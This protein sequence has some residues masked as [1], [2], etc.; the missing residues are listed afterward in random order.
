MVIKSAL[1]LFIC[2]MA[3]G[4]AFADVLTGTDEFAPM[5]C[6]EL[7]EKAMTFR[8]LSVEI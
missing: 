8:L 1:V 5:S 6:W 4:V 3:S 7:R 2:V